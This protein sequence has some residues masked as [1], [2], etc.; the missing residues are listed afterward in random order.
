M[1]R[2]RVGAVAVFRRSHVVARL[3]KTRS[4]KVLRSTL[5]SIAEGTDVRIPSTIDD[6]AIL[7]EIA[8]VLR[9]G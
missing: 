9:P 2:D 6:P 5:R 7:D 4:G 8:P 3:P 1:V